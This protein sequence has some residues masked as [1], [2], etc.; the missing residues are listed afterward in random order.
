MKYKTIFVLQN[1]INLQ[2]IGIFKSIH[3]INEYIQEYYPPEFNIN[4]LTWTEIIIEI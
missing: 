3:S 1:A 4:A 2:P